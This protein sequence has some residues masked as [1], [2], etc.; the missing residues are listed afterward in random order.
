M[1][2]FR[3]ADSLVPNSADQVSPI[4]LENEVDDGARFRVF[5]GVAQKI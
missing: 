2:L 3:Y 5:H 4:L 1:V